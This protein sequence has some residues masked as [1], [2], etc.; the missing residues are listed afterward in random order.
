MNSK[1]HDLYAELIRKH[2]D[3]PNH[4][5]RPAFP[6]ESIHAYN[7]VCG[8]KFVIYVSKDGNPLQHL[9]FQGIG[10]AISKASASMMLGLI[11]GKSI[12]EARALG[13]LFIRYLHGED[14]DIP[15]E[16]QAFAGI[17]KFPERFDCAALPWLSLD[18]FYA[19]H[20]PHEN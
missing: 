10:C 7:P 2:N 13:T 20:P 14:I 11:K 19:A 1:P 8:D 4:F 9:A 3:Q 15:Q 5:N 17:R 12:G 18:A 6:A 16:L